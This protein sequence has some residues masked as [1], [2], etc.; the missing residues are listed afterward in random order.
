MDD[1]KIII[2]K[3]TNKVEKEVNKLLKKGYELHGHLIHSVDHTTSTP[4]PL[5]TQVV[6][7]YPEKAVEPKKQQE[8]VVNVVNA[9]DVKVDTPE[10]KK[11][12]K[13]VQLKGKIRFLRPKY[14]R[15]CF[16]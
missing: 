7:K 10:E 5:Y 4:V 13:A 16:C 12:V 15:Q 14:R 11:K 9:T 6:V 2:D 8:T 3:E 1:Y